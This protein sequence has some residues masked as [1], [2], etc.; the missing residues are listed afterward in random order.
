MSEEDNINALVHFST[1]V[2][3]CEAHNAMYEQGME[4]FKEGINQYS[5][6][7]V[8][9]FN[10][11]VNGFVVKIFLGKSFNQLNQLINNVVVPPSLNYT[12]LGYVTAVRNQVNFCHQSDIFILNYFPGTL[13][14]LLGIFRNW[15]T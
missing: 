15:R 7:S 2:A 12:A 14:K 10:D 13:R 5:D 3:A 8:E 4:T 9:E 1:R 6:L 11:K